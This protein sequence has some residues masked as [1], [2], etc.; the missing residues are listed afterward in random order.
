MILKNWQA[1]LALYRTN[2]PVNHIEAD[3]YFPDRSQHY[4]HS[5]GS[6]EITHVEFDCEHVW[7]TK[8]YRAQRLLCAPCNERATKDRRNKMLREIR[9]DDRKN[10][11]CA[12]CDINF[13]P[14]RKD[15]KY[16]S[17]A[18]RVKAYRKRKAG[19]VDP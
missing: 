4:C 2:W 19:V 13:D 18:C 16:C 14:T 3:A 15:A 6:V 10:T 11:S 8:Q 17:T 1:R 12:Q 5:C 7:K 9:E